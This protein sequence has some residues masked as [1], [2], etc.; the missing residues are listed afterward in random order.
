MIILHTRF[1]FWAPFNRKTH[2]S[3]WGVS[4]G[5]KQFL[6]KALYKIWHM[7]LFSQTSQQTLQMCSDTCVKA[8]RNKNNQNNFSWIQFGGGCLWKYLEL[9]EIIWLHIRTQNILLMACCSEEVGRLLPTWNLPE[10]NN[11]ALLW[12]KKNRNNRLF[13]HHVVLLPHVH[14]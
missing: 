8:A 7:G 14:S 11:K 1:S 3:N 6:D 2:F 12:A 4:Q 10:P 9:E 13:F 5:L